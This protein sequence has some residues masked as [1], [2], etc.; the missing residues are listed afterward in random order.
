M[1]VLCSTRSKK[2]FYDENTRNY[3]FGCCFVRV[4]NLVSRVQERPKAEGCFRICC[5]GRHSDL[6]EARLE[7]NT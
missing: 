5:R 3:N 4:L 6:R 2:A 1:D 7:K